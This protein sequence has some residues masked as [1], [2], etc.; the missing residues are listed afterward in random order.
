MRIGRK[1]LPRIGGAAAGYPAASARRHSRGGWDFIFHFTTC[2]PCDN[3]RPARY[4]GPEGA[5][6]EGRGFL[7]ARSQPYGWPPS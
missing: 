3:R 4:S 7:V 6:R 1:P 2:L 5:R